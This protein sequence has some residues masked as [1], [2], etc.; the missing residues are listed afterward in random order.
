MRAS[1]P[2]TS[3]RA[4][5]SSSTSHHLAFPGEFAGSSDRA[6]PSISFGLP[7]DDRMSIAASEHE[8]GS[9]DGDSAA[10]APSRRVALPE[11]D[12]EL[13]A[14]LCRAAKSIGLHWRPPTSPEC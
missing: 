4:S 5:R 13:N 6:W 1:L 9:G 10:L 8:L 14:M 3:P 2:S 7:A 12:A 11:S